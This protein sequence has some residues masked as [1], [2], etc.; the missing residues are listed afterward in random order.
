MEK[1]DLINKPSHY[2][3]HS[4]QPVVIIED[5]ELGFLL[6]NSF[7]YVTRCKYKGKEVEDLGKAI[8]YIDLHLSST[9]KNK[10]NRYS[11]LDISKIL[12]EYNLGMELSNAMLC[13][14]YT[15]DLSMAK[16]YIKRYINKLKERVSSGD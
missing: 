4:I 13:I 12:S 14:L 7:K 6:G 11:D 5:F 15:E 2:N 1:E 8:N 16:I 9:K 3:Q 10:I